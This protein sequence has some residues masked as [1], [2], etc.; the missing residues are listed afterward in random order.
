MPARADT[1]DALPLLLRAGEVSRL[2]GLDR[3]TIYRLHSSGRLPAPLKIGGSTRWRAEELRAWCA[4]GC[5]PRSR[6]Q[7]SEKERSK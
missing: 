4:A 5:P 3:S 1:T 6:W 2:L 7:W